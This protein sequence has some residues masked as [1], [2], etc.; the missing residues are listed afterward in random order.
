MN[1]AICQIVAE[2]VIQAL[3]KGVVPW[4]KP[5]CDVCCSAVSY[6]TGK[7]YSLLNQFLLGRSGE[8]LTFQQAKRAGGCVKKGAK[9]SKVVFWS[10]LRYDENGR[11]IKSNNKDVEVANTVPYLRYY[12][13]F[14][15]DDC[16]G[17]EAKIKE[18]MPCG[19]MTN[20]DVEAIIERYAKDNGLTLK[21][22]GKSNRACYGLLTDTVTIPMIEQFENTAEYYSTVFHELV[23][24][25]GHESR[26]NRFDLSD[27]SQM[28]F[29]SDT[30]SREELIAEIGAATIMATLGIETESQF[31]NS[32]SYIG[33]WRNRIAEDNSLIVVAAGRAE[34]AIRMILGDSVSINVDENSENE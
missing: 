18:E 16:D 14:H 7:S 11:L 30:Y 27:K 20:Y 29:G 24:S 5:W 9:S 13:V 4:N 21:R 28:S 17:I 8:Y 3:D 34:K 12:N 26:L 23:H 32:V 31:A 10:F 2:R 25:T 19:A 15:I 1:E 6:A 33:N 22:E